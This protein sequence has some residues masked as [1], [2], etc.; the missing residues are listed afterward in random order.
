MSN[1]ATCTTDEAVQIL[2]VSRATVA[3]FIERG[4]LVGRKEE[5][6]RTRW[7]LDRASVMA[8]AA[9]Q[10]ERDALGVSVAP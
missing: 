5:C 1:S 8:L 9:Q 4:L 7:L 3:N 10:A 2:G 6:N